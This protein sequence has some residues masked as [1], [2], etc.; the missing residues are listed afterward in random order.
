MLLLPYTGLFI[1]SL[2]CILQPNYAVVILTLSTT[3]LNHWLALKQVFVTLQIRGFVLFCFVLLAS[4]F[5]IPAL[6]L[7]ATVATFLHECM[8][9]AFCFRWPWY[10]PL[11]QHLTQGICNSL[12]AYLS[13]Q[14]NHFSPYVSC[15]VWAR[16]A[17][18]K[19]F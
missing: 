4:P 15:N 2:S 7:P 5:F 9:S 14:I 13:S 16:E 12:F 11:S 10:V 1:I 18:N 3:I 8:H 17:L 6:I 19:F